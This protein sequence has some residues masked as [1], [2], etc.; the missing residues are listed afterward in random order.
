VLVWRAKGGFLSSLMFYPPGK[1]PP[2]NA[3]SGV[4]IYFCPWYGI[5]LENATNQARSITSGLHVIPEL[6]METFTCIAPIRIR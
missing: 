5:D 4:R 1:Q 3:E 6:P 2:D